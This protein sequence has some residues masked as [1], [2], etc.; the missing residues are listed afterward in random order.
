MKVHANTVQYRIKRIRD[1][2]GVDITGNTIVP[3]L[4]TALAVSRIEK[5]VKS[6]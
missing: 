5:E 3:G 2:L 1:I 6:F 4:M